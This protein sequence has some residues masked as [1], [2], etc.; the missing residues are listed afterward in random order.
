MMHHTANRRG[1]LCTWSSASHRPG[2][3]A[4]RRVYAG[5]SVAATASSCSGVSH[6][7]Q[8]WVV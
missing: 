6:W 3:E 5:P 1:G 2:S 8:L 7:I 4:V